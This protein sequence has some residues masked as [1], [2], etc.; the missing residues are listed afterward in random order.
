MVSF[1]FE[2]PSLQVSLRDFIKKDYLLLKDDR[3]STKMEVR[4][5]SL[6]LKPH[7]GTQEKIRAKDTVIND[8]HGASN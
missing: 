2:S 3:S 1:F 6:Y 4:D 8:G 7:I 5:S